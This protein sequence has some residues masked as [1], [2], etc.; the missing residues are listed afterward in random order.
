LFEA[1]TQIMLSYRL[2]LMSEDVQK[3]LLRMAAEI[4]RMLNGLTAL[5]RK[6]AAEEG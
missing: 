1:D 3:R 5:E 2:G 6:L 4:G